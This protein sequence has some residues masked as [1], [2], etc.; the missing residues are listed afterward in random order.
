MGYFKKL[1]ATNRIG[2]NLQRFEMGALEENLKETLPE[3][4]ENVLQD[5]V[6]VCEEECCEDQPQVDIREIA[7]AVIK[8]LLV[9]FA[10]TIKTQIVDVY[11]A[12]LANLRKEISWG[13]DKHDPYT[14]STIAGQPKTSVNKDIKTVITTK[15]EERYSSWD[16][17]SKIYYDRPNH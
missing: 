10:D 5:Y 14:P 13:R 7:D 2:E 4:L 17:S 12:Q 1:A 16:K 11:E 6:S 15:A 9:D 3:V 8:A